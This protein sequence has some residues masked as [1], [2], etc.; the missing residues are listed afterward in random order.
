MLCMK[1]KVHWM[2]SWCGDATKAPF[3][4]RLV[5]CLCVCRRHLVLCLFLLHLLQKAWSRSPPCASPAGKACGAL[6]A[7][8]VAPFQPHQRRARQL[9]C[10]LKH[11]ICSHAALRALLA[12]CQCRLAPSLL[13]HPCPGAKLLGAG[14]LAEATAGRSQRRH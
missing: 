12:S 3:C 9:G 13:G 7:C 4:E 5:T 8:W 11:G 1:M 2:K 14:W 6:L 10:Q